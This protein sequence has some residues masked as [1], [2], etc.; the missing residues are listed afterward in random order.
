MKQEEIIKLINTFDLAVR[1]DELRGS[2][3][4]AEF[5]QSLFDYANARTAL[6]NS[7]KYLTDQRRNKR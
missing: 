3:S 6:I 4:P 1:A 5:T 7:V 2:Q